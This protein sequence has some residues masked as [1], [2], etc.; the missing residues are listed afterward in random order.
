MD[1]LYDEP[2]KILKRHHEKMI[3]CYGKEGWKEQRELALQKMTAIL[4]KQKKNEPEKSR[5][6]FWLENDRQILSGSKSEPSSI[7]TKEDIPKYSPWELTEEDQK[8][9]MVQFRKELEWK[10]QAQQIRDPISGKNMLLGDFERKYKTKKYSNYL[11]DYAVK[12]KQIPKKIYAEIKQLPNAIQ[13]KEKFQSNRAAERATL[14]V[15]VI[16]TGIEPVFSA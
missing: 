16:P 9:C 11:Y 5:K 14:C 10:R 2:D 3:E 12:D 15:L 8:E 6:K 7:D 1:V 4:E 13:A